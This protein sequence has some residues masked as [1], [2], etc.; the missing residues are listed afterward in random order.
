MKKGF[1]SIAVIVFAVLVAGI[2]GYFAVV[3]KQ[4]SAPPPQ[5]STAPTNETA[6]WKTYQNK[7]YGFEVKYPEELALQEDANPSDSL[8]FLSTW[9]GSGIFYSI[10]I[11]ATKQNTLEGWFDEEFKDRGE[12]LP[13]P[14]KKLIDFNGYQ[15]LAI[16]D[17]VTLGGCESEYVAVIN[18]G[19]IYEF[20]NPKC[21][22]VIAPDASYTLEK[23]NSTFKFIP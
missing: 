9:R 5:P 21:E 15:A 4:A 14:D 23:I 1:V 18:G 16:S 17:P 2:V 10:S 6:N 3:K 11:L 8:I 22:S 20:L 7:Q 19:F 13:K 12:S